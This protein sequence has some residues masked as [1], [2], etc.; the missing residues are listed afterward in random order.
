M[1][2]FDDDSLETD[3]QNYNE[4]NHKKVFLNVGDN[5]NKEM[6][7]MDQLQVDK[8]RDDDLKVA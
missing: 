6:Y 1:T 4:V 8:I 3:F 7:N 5:Q 2:Q